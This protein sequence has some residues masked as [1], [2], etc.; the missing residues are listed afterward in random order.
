ML[1][2]AYNLCLSIYSGLSAEG[3]G[4]TI[5]GPAPIREEA[6]ATHPEAN[7]KVLKIVFI[8]LL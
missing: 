7:S 4:V 3:S 8:F 2:F 5:E 6:V 1:L